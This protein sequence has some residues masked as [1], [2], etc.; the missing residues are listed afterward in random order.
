[1][2]EAKEVILPERATLLLDDP[3][4]RIY[5]A[6]WRQ[7]HEI[8]VTSGEQIDGAIVDCPYSD[9]THDGHHTEGSDG[10][11][12][13]DIDYNAWSKT[14]V[15][16]FCDAYIPLTRGWFI[17][18]TDVN[19]WPIWSAAMERHD[20]VTFVDVPS[21]IEGMTV[22]KS[23]DGPSSWT[24]HN[25]ISRP[26]GEPWSK[27]GTMPGA[28]V[29]KREVQPIMGGKPVWLQEELVRGRRKRKDDPGFGGYMRP[30]TDAFDGANGR[31][32]I[33]P[34]CGG[35]TIAIPCIKGQI[36]VILGD[37]DLAHA[38]VAVKRCRAELAKYSGPAT[39]FTPGA[40]PPKM[41]Q[42]SL[43]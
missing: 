27:W 33:D 34:C 22:R 16:A 21:V 38:Q 4:C 17:S 43:C 41:V 15:D 25:A 5:H 13:R 18:Q 20:R 9:K 2:G 19:L 39:R 26:R 11:E 8:L 28:Y 7:L 40:P 30:A 32:L 12:R 42:Q 31:T 23:G 37:Q 29:G 10:G 14:D 35:G 6:T 1:V 36:N 24:I 3:R